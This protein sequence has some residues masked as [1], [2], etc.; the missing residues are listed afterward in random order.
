MW[1]PF[2]AATCVLNALG[3]FPNSAA[4]RT[5]ATGRECIPAY[6]AGTLPVGVPVRF[7]FAL[8]A[9]NADIVH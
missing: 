9:A 3:I 1:A 4:P 8:G 6:G 2:V 7:P 5:A